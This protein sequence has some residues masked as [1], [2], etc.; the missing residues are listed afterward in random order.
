MDEMSL[1][2]KFVESLAILVREFE[3]KTGVEV[4]GID[5]DRMSIDSEG[6]LSEET[7]IMRIKLEMR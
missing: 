7:A 3:D 6:Q 5:F 4:F 2:E 1:K